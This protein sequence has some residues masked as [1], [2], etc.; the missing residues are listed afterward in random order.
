VHPLTTGAVTYVVQ[1]VESL[2]ALFYLG[3]IYC[4][5]RAGETGTRR[6]LWTAAAVA[7]CALGMATKEPMVTA[8]L[9]VWLW[10]VVFAKAPWLPWRDADRRVL[11]AGLAATW[12]V[13]AVLL[14]T[15]SQ[16][17]VVLRSVTSSGQVEDWPA[18]SY[19]WTQAGV[20]LHYLRLVVWPSPL[21]F[22]YYGWPRADSVLEVWPQVLAVAALVGVSAFGLMRRHPLG[23]V[24][25]AFFII[26]APTSSIVPISTEPA[27]EHRMY[28]PLAALI[29]GAIAGAATVVVRRRAT[30]TIAAVVVVGLA[31]VAATATR[32]RNQVY[33][34]DEQLWADTVAARPGNARARINYGINLVA[35]GRDRESEAQM[36][37]A[38]DLPAD[39]ETRA[40]IH[41]QLGS[42]LCASGRLR[43]G[44]PHVERALAID[45][46]LPEA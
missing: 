37:A 28:L 17:Q 4:A 35:S 19:L 10:S 21:A 36:R 23:F 18:M 13:L 33:W 8:P 40:Q 34:S 2:M 25:A 42:A 38:L 11:H 26:L 39:H 43:E 15:Q 9:V 24:G 32:T 7:A 30:A 22:D 12:L 20:V 27:A 6:S 29:A 41:L 45:P 46:D 1:R 44:I 3:T 5:I 31:V 14:T 16:A